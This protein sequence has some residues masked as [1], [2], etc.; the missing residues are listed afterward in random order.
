PFA[1][2]ILETTKEI[3]SIER[4]EAI[5]NI[6]KLQRDIQRLEKEAPHQLEGKR[7]V[8][9]MSKPGPQSHI[10]IIVSRKDVSNRYSLSPGSKYRATEVEMHGKSV[11]RGFDRDTF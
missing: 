1:T 9:G 7:I 3:R 6:K 5:G 2:K 10:H 11:K 8:R 4:G